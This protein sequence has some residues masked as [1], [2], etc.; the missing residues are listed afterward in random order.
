M[1]TV[2]MI[3]LLACITVATGLDCTLPSHSSLTDI[4]HYILTVH[5][6]VNASELANLTIPQENTTYTCLAAGETV[7]RYRSFSVVV[8]YRKAPEQPPEFA[9][10]QAEC[11]AGFIWESGFGEFE[12]ADESYLSRPLRED[13]LLCSDNGNDH[14]NCFLGELD[15]QLLCQ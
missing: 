4:L 11:K 2:P 7:L 5:Q 12:V 15:A 14:S 9:Q 1:A 3:L 13:C 10:F 6:G 8:Q